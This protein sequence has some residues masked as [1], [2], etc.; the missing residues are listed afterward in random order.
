MSEA[1]RDQNHVPSI[2][3]TLNTDGET[4][5][6]VKASPEHR[7]KVSDGVGGSDSG[8]SDANRDQNHVPVMI[9]VS[10]D[11]GSTP[12][13]LYADSNGKLLVQTT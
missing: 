6:P 8:P 3:A 12:V 7:L 5:V 13:V 1:V 2:L 11:D 10:D 4:S 9:A